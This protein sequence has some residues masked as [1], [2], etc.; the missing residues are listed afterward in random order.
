MLPTRQLS[1]LKEMLALPTA[2]FAERYVM[3][4]IVRFCRTRGLKVGR[5]PAGNLLVRYRHGRRRVR[6]PVC[7]T[8]HMDHPGFVVERMRDRRT[9]VVTWRGGV[10]PEYFVGAR[11]R[12]YDEASARNGPTAGRWVH[13]RIRSIR[14]HSTGGVARVQSAD[15][16]V[17]TELSPGTIGMWDFPDPR[18]RG[19]RIFAR[20]CDDVAGAAAILCC[21][22]ELVRQRVQTD[23]YVLFT[24]AEEVGFVGAIAA[25]RQRTVPDKCLVVSVE[26]SSQLPHARI[27]AGPILRVGDKSSTFTPTATAYARRAAEKLAQ[28]DKSFRFQRRLMD[29]GTCEST[30]FCAFGY[31]A[32]GLCVALGN[33]HNMNVRRHRLGPEYIDLNDFANLVRWFVALTR[34]AEPF[35]GRDPALRA[36]L[37]RLERTHAELLAHSRN[38]ALSGAPISHAL[39][40]SVYRGA[41]S[42]TPR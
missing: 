10:R 1:I 32:T 30:A 15:V 25:C 14:K 38:G 5:D 6:R 26:T 37:E 11:V 23:V 35:D 18:V 34:A 33:Y 27:G 29:G 28:A 39:R 24:R 9:A 20:G 8:A 13:G 41:T 36:S 22:D 7:L 40:R 42:K 16:A 12:F 19:T 31:T 2:P 21:L 4:A 17:G 3:N